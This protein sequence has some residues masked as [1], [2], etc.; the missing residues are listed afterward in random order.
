MM[1]AIGWAL[2]A[3]V[4]VAGVAA[5]LAHSAMIASVPKDGAK[6]PAGLAEISFEFSKPLRLTVVDV[7]RTDDQKKVGFAGAPPKSFEKS[8][9]LAI[10]PLSAGAYTVSWT[11]VAA[12]GHVMKGV[13]SFSVED[14]PAAAPA[15]P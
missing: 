7:V 5:A 15:K 6:A 10:E 1:R 4:V 3:I 11:G 9:K 12:D 8:A 2:A 13:F 14:A